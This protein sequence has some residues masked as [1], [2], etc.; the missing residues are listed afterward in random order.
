MLE[1]GCVGDVDFSVKV[2]IGGNPLYGCEVFYFCDVT[3]NFG[4][5]A[6]CYSAVAVYVAQN[7]IIGYAARYNVP[8][9]IE[10]GESLAVRREKRLVVNRRAA[11]IFTGVV[12]VKVG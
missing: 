10:G 5:V 11:V 9:N 3:L 6:D 12:W 7:V 4:G 2:K 8:E 1:G